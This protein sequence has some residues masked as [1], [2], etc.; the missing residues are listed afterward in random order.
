MTRI[1]TDGIKKEM[2]RSQN[3]EGLC[4]SRTKSLARRNPE[5]HA[6]LA[7]MEENQDCE[8]IQE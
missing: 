5:E 2:V 7:E 4:K 8:G 6:I 1:V 3:E